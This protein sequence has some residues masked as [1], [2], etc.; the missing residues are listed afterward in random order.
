MNSVETLLSHLRD[1]GVHVTWSGVN[2]DQG[3][4]I[5]FRGAIPK[6][7]KAEILR[8]QNELRSLVH[9]RHFNLTPEQPHEPTTTPLSDS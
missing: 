8:L 5:L 1:A 7:L 4:F 6:E 3:G 9:D 2:I